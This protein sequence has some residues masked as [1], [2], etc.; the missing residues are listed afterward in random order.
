MIWKIIVSK[1][2]AS[3]IL[4]QEYIK[5]LPLDLLDNEYVA[6]AKIMVAVYTAIAS[7]KNTVRHFAVKVLLENA[8]ENW[9]KFCVSEK[10]ER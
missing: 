2:S 7:F 9:R 10:I 6:D 3:D 4:V 8:G 5:S 1:H